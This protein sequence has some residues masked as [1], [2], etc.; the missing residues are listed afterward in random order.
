MTYPSRIYILLFTRIYIF[1]LARW[2]TVMSNNLKIIC[3]S[4]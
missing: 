1:L 2:T 4:L 3:T